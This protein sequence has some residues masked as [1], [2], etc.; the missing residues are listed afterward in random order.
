MIALEKSRKW[1]R[2]PA[3]KMRTFAEQKASN[4]PPGEVVVSGHVCWRRRGGLLFYPGGL[5]FV[6]YCR[7]RSCEDQSPR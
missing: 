5:F 3:V 4:G 1:S 2:C 7:I 6:T